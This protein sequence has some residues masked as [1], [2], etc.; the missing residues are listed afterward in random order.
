[1]SSS[2][3]GVQPVPLASTLEYSPQF[4]DRPVHDRVRR[5]VEHLADDLTADPSVRASLH[6]DE[7]RH[8]VLI[9]EE[10]INRP[11]PTAILFRRQRRLSADQQPSPSCPARKLITGQE[12]WEL[13]DQRLENVLGMVR[14]LDHSQKLVL[15]AQQEDVSAHAWSLRLADCIAPSLL[16]HSRW[17]PAWEARLYH[18]PCRRSC[19]RPS[20]PIA[21]EAGLSSSRTPRFRSDRP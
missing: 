14:R 10:M 13:R 7:R 15:A 17:V 12:I 9:Q 11:T 5:V 20:S 1:A 4:F 18:Q 3:S 2:V 16:S 21:T 19:Q 6:L 8:G